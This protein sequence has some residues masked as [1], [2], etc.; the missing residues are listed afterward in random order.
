MKVS[1]E[2]FL[3][4]SENCIFCS[5]FLTQVQYDV[6]QT[7]KD[8]NYCEPEEEQRPAVSGYDGYY[9]VLMSAKSDA[10]HDF[11]CKFRTIACVCNLHTKNG[12]ITCDVV[13]KPGNY[14]LG[15]KSND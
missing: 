12:V 8:I 7:H 11:L 3:S 15:P 2:D 6:L 9:Y 1:C 4:V 10:L 13:E 14:I 5:A